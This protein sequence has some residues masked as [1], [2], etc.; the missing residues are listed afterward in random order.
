MRDRGVGTTSLLKSCSGRRLVVA[1]LLRPTKLGLL[2]ALSTAVLALGLAPAGASAEPLCTDTWTGPAEGE[3]TT[4]ADWSSKAVPGSTSVACI[5]SGD[6]VTVPSG[7]NHTG[8]VQGAGT[9]V[10]RGGSLELADTLEASVIE[11]FSLFGGSLKGAGALDVTGSFDWEGTS[12]ISGSGSFV[13]EAGAEGNIHMYNESSESMSLEGRTFVNDGTVEFSSG[14]LYMSDGAELENSGTFGANSQQERAPYNATIEQPGSEGS[15]PSIVNTGLIKDESGSAKIDVRLENQGTV[16]ADA[17]KLELLDGGSGTDGTWSG[18]SG[19]SLTFGGSGSTYSLDDGNLSGGL[20]VD[21][22]AVSTEGLS[23][24][25]AQVTVRSGSLTVPSGTL[26]VEDFSLFGGSLTGA[27]SLEVTGF[28]NWEGTST[29]SGN[30]SLILAHGSEGSIHEYNESRESMTLEKRTFV[31]DGTVNFWDGT[32]YMS[33]DAELINEGTFEDNSSETQGPENEHPRIKSPY[34]EDEALIVNYNTLV[35]NEGCCAATD[36]AVPLENL[37]LIGAPAGY[38]G[39]VVLDPIEAA[40]ETVWGGPENP[41]APEEELPMCG[42]SVSCDGDYSQ[43][44]TDLAI[45]GRG[46]GLDLTRTYNSQAAALGVHG[47][48]GYGWSSS[49]SDHLVLEPSVHR[50]T[51]VQADGS[52][53]PFTEGTG[54][55]F[56]APAWTQD[57][58]S[59]SS[60]TGY[61]LTLEDQTVYKFSGGGRLES[62]TDRNGNATTLAYNGSGELETITDPSGRTIKLAY[63]SEGLVESATDPMKHVIKYTYEGGNLKSV[64]QPGETALRW[65]F[66]YDS[67]HEITEMIDGREGKTVNKYDSSHQET[68]QTD[69]MGH[70]TKFEYESFRTLTTNEVTGAVTVQYLTSSGLSSAIT[71]GF[72]TSH[73]TTETSTYNSADELLSSTNG[74]G[75]TTKYTYEHGNRISMVDPDNHETKWTYDSTH[76]VETEKTPDGETTTYKRDSHGNVLTEERPAPGSTTQSTSYKYTAHGQVESMTNPLSHTWKYEYDS[77][78]DRTAEMDPEGDKRTWG[79]NE[80]SEET[81]MVS[82]RGHVSG[83]K[84]SSFT[85]TTERDAR[86]LPVKIIAPLKHETIEEYDGDNN[87]I[88]KTDPEGDTTKYVYNADNELEETLEPNKD[89]TKTEYDGAGQVVEQTNGDKQSTTYTPNVLEQIEEITDP[90]G[91]KTSKEYDAAG[92]LVSETDAQKRTTTYKYDPDNRLVEITYSDGKAPTVKYEYNGDGKRTKM[93]DGTGTTIYEYDQLDRLTSITDGHSESV[94]YEYN[95][96]NE[97]TKITYP[98]GKA[99]TREYDNAG[100]L[101]S[102]KDW[103]SN[104]TKFTYDADSDLT[105]TTFPSGTSDEDKYVYN[106]ADGMS[107]VKMTKGSETLASL[108]YTRNKDEDVTK[109]TS[110]GLPGEEKP[111]YTYD[112]NSRITKGAD[113]SYKYDEANTPT[114]IGNYTL[115]YNAADEPEKETEKT[116]TKA[117]YTYNEVG[118]RTKTTPATGAATTYEYNQAGDLIGVTR[119]KEGSTPAIEDTYTY[120]GD[121]LRIAKTASS[122]TTYFA[123]DVA[124]SLPLVLGD[125]TNSYVYGPESEPI[126]QINDTTGTV[127]YV[128]HDQQGSTRLLT[129]STGAKEASFTYD[130]YGNQT[131]HTGTATTPLGYDG[132]Y[133][134]ADTGLIYLRARE[135]DPATAQFLSVDPKAEE[136]NAVY[137]YAKDDPLTNSDPTGEGPE[138]SRV[139]HEFLS[140]E[141]EGLKQLKRKHASSETVEFFQE[142]IKVHFFFEV[143]FAEGNGTLQRSGEQELQRIRKQLV[144][145]FA[146]LASREISLPAL[147]KALWQ[148]YHI[149]VAVRLGARR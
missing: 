41:S 121:G 110:V 116:T 86:G 39:I 85:T 74:D 131:G 135:Y 52:H 73:A 87:L 37:G 45:G 43:T 118:E 63:N 126:E 58:L 65:Q 66:K 9:L 101:K 75:H 51:L 124:E 127:L 142:I 20:E 96:A 7:S 24:S 29:I 62:V 35:Q 26:V 11:G 30:G 98:S 111:S 109:A 12:S 8:V 93:T 1:T 102:V 100:R 84:E 145:K 79:Y 97:Q 38:G 55:T 139:A 106:E 128:H 120:N 104:T 40:P 123:W 25:G 70:V 122:V 68:E 147:I 72:G 76:D 141:S 94:G 146:P 5:G 15:A 49:F 77:A 99:V 67:S 105:A 18:P 3:W 54:S 81:S 83:A 108:V 90:L 42:E 48:F 143:A 27:G 59:G 82:P 112:E 31:N 125:G 57:V 71:K 80:D 2:I 138:E 22:G 33:D 69:P 140:L 23:S 64:T 16:E 103:L 107:E 137:G 60:A 117:T 88:K 61:T 47:A 92:N 132:Q 56:T 28:F 130:A 114:T 13:L 129:G 44:Q 17:R 46:V 36:I 32:L 10:V 95:L 78:G 89:T 119:P 148:I 14:I 50:A 19:G 6:T 4:A 53:V 21:G 113:V 144:G 149:S 34:G 133:T 91:R 115:S 136:T 134:N